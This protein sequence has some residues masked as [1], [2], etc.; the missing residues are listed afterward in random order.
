MAFLEDVLT[1]TLSP[2]DNPSVLLH[3]RVT[4]LPSTWTTVQ[5][6]FLASAIPVPIVTARLMINAVIVFF[7]K[8]S[9]LVIVHVEL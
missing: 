2:S 6:M 3:C 8:C 9:S 7:M 5:G 1:L 4:V